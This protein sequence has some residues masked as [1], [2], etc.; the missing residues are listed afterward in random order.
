MQWA[1]STDLPASKG[2]V[3]PLEPQQG[4]RVQQW[5][6][7]ASESSLRL[8][9]SVTVGRIISARGASLLKAFQNCPHGVPTERLYLERAR[10]MSGQL[11]SIAGLSSVGGL[12]TVGRAKFC[13]HRQLPTP[14]SGDRTAQL[15]LGRTHLSSR[16]MNPRIVASTPTPEPSSEGAML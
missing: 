7:Q 8:L 16:P 3:R 11:D 10:V 13:T 15:T 9:Q 4:L 2:D 6:R 1:L 12:N 14:R 5:Q